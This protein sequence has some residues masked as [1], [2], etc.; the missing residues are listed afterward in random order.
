MP[1]NQSIKSMIHKF[2]F[3]EKM[4]LN[5]NIIPHPLVDTSTNVGLAKALGVSVKLK[6]TD[7]LGENPKSASSIAKNCGVSEKGVVL[8][9]NCLEALDYVSKSEAGYRFTRRG[10]KFLDKN[11]PN[12]F[13]N[14]IL[15]AN[16]TFNSFTSLENTVKSG[17]N[18]R[19]NL[20][21]FGDYE[22]EIFSRAMIEIARTNVHDVVKKIEIPPNAKQVIDLGGSHGL[23]SIELCR[24]KQD[25]TAIVLDFE[26]VRKYTDECVKANQMAD[27]VKFQECDFRKQALPTNSDIALMF[28]IIHG[29]QAEENK[30][31]FSKVFDVLNEGG[32]LVILD[33]IKG[34]AGGSQLAR[35]T[36]SFM[37]LN[38]FHQANGNTYYFEEVKDWALKAGFKSAK[39]KKLKTPGFALI[40]CKK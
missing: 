2:S 29:L 40:I 25:L 22:W 27:R 39:L 13:R 11:S 12:N 34:T 8:V 23:Y 19:T 30:K 1:K 10:T 26:P 28:N 15:Y 4:L 3:I 16:W 35:A 17:V 33:Q 24:K 7:E 9:L 5:S 18:E 20:E 21:Q 37:A 14:F 32:Q 31:V 36:T 6:I 38:L